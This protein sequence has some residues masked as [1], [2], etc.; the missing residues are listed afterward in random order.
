MPTPP[1]ASPDQRVTA[2]RIEIVIE[3]RNPLAGE[4]QVEG[5]VSAF[6]GWLDL[7]QILS[8]L[9]E[10]PPSGNGPA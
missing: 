2:D 1:R 8:P 5:A 10:A 6:S 4:V 7:L 3:S 9:V